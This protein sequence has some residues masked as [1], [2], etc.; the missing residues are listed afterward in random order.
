MI[1]TKKKIFNLS[2]QKNGTKS[3]HLFCK[4]KGLNSL[5]WLPENPL[6]FEQ[7]NNEHF[8]AIENISKCSYEDNSIELLYTYYKNNFFE[9]YDSFCDFPI[10]IFYNK[11]MEEYPGS[12][13]LLFYR[14]VDEWINSIRRHYLNEGN[15]NFFDKLIY[16][17]LSNIKKNIVDYTNE[18][19]KQIYLQHIQNVLIKSVAN[20]I[21]LYIIYLKSN[22]LN[23]VLNNIIKTSKDSMFGKYS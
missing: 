6:N 21:N 17:N 16:F 13:F 15:N 2:L 11:I 8:E 14:D 23:S 1:E 10:P 19:L 20:K 7:Y 3:F 9:K 22:C 12:I 18:E 5:H 4:N